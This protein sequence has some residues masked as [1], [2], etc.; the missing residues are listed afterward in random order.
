MVKLPDP[1]LHVVVFKRM[2]DDSS[3]MAPSFLRFQMHSLCMEIEELDQWRIRP[4]CV[5]SGDPPSRTSV[6][7]AVQGLQGPPGR[8][9]SAPETRTFSL[10]IPVDSGRVAPGHEAPHQFD[11]S[12]RHFRGRAGPVRQD[13][14][15]RPSPAVGHRAEYRGPLPTRFGRRALPG[16]SSTL[17]EVLKSAAS[18]CLTPGPSAVRRYSVPR[19]ACSSRGHP[20]ILISPDAAGRS[21]M[22]CGPGPSMLVLSSGASA[23]YAQ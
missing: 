9:S 1:A 16:S 15:Y 3:E 8:I 22:L 4:Q 5:S 21:F 17:K 11:H 14:H 20:G 2:S 23:P 6:S 12:S 18:L 7:S 13:A 19:S 10:W